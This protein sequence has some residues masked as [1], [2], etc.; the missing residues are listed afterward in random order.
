MPPP[1]ISWKTSLLRSPRIPPPT[2][3]GNSQ[4]WLRDFSS[5]L[6]KNTSTSFQVGTS[7]EGVGDLYSKLPMNTPPKLELLMEELGT[8]VLSFPRIPH[9]PQSK[10][11]LLIKDLRFWFWAH[12]G[13][14]CAH[15]T[16]VGSSHGRLKAFS[17]ELPKYTPT[18]MGSS[19]GGLRDFG[20]ELPKNIPPPKLDLLLEDLG[21]SVQ[22]FK[23]I[24]HPRQMEFLL[25]D[26][27]GTGVWRLIT[28]S[29]ADTVSLIHFTSRIIAKNQTVDMH[30]FVHFVRKL[31]SHE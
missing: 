29:P 14:P 1:P 23:R 30:V 31:G 5:E 3:I 10:L 26:S 6:P 4:G 9:P 16:Q 8:S 2:Q 24:P 17:S 27:V 12:Q 15:P 19:Q 25:E 7:H 21:T 18:Q 11:E 13:Y 22:S 20:S 28:A